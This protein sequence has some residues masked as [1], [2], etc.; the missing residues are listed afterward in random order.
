[1]FRKFASILIVLIVAFSVASPA[2]A[3]GKEVSFNATYSG[4]ATADFSIGSVTFNGT[5]IATHLGF[6]TNEGHI[7]ITG[8]IPNA[9]CYGGFELPNIHNETLTAANGDTLL[10]TLT[11]VAC[12]ISPLVFHGT[13]SWIVA[14]GTGRF[15]GVTGKGIANGIV[16]FNRSVFYLKLTGNISLPNGG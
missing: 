2:Y 11:D 10:L 9:N 16:D 1:M 5:G 14:G 3:S 15:N 8:Q 13:G 4:K 7:Q 6:S 12:P